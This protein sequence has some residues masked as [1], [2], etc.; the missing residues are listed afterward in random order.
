M[1]TGR[2]EGNQRRR[3]FLSERTLDVVIL[4]KDDKCW[5]E[6]GLYTSPGMHSAT[7]PA[8]CGGLLGVM[9]VVVR[10]DG[11]VHRE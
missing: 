9:M 11:Y 4:H 8:L 2:E 1:A 7:L 3:R 6:G 5:E 10:S